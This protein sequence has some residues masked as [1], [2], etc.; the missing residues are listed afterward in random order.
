MITNTDHD[1]C[2]NANISDHTNNIGMI[3]SIDYSSKVNPAWRQK[4]NGF[5]FDECRRN[6]F[7]FVDNGA[8]LEIDL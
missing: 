6:G 8:V 2:L 3:S 5:L 4:L 7:K 1:P